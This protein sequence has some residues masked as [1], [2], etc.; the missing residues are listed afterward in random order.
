MPVPQITN[1]TTNAS[2]LKIQSRLQKKILSKKTETTE[3]TDKKE[4]ISAPPK[5]ELPSNTIIVDDRSISILKIGVDSELIFDCYGKL[6]YIIINSNCYRNKVN[7]T[8]TLS[9]PIPDDLKLFKK[10]DIKNISTTE[11]GTIIAIPTSKLYSDKYP[12]TETETDTVS[13]ILFERIGI[14][15]NFDIRVIERLKFNNINIKINQVLDIIFVNMNNF[16]I[17]IKQDTNFHLVYYFNSNEGIDSSSVSCSG[18]FSAD[19][20][21]KQA[22]EY[23]YNHMIINSFDNIINDYNYIC[24]M[25]SIYDITPSVIYIL[26]HDK[27]Y[28][29]LI[30]E[31]TIGMYEHCG[32][33]KPLIELNSI[34][35]ILYDIGTYLSYCANYNISTFSILLELP[36]KDKCFYTGIMDIT[37]PDVNMITKIKLSFSQNTTFPK[38][39]STIDAQYM[40]YTIMKKTE[41][42]IKEEEYNLRQEKLKKQ[43]KKLDLKES[44]LKEQEAINIAE[45][46]LKEEEAIKSKAKKQKEKKVKAETKKAILL[47]KEA[48]EKEKLEKEEILLKKEALEKEEIL[49]K[50]EA[51]EKEEILLK[52]EALEKEALEK[53]ALEKE[54]ILLKKEALEKEKLEKEAN[55]FKQE[56]LE[57][58]ILLKKERDEKDILLKQIELLEK[59]KLEKEHQILQLNSITLIKQ[60]LPNYSTNIIFQQFIYYMSVINPS[61]AH[62]LNYAQSDYHYNLLLFNNKNYVMNI[63]DILVMNHSHILYLKNIMI[64]DI[65]NKNN[66]SYQKLQKEGF[67]IFALYGSF[68]PMIYSLVLNNIGYIFNAF[69][70]TINPLN[71]LKDYDTLVLKLLDDYV[72]TETDYEFIREKS[73]IIG[74]QSGNIEDN[75]KSQFNDYQYNNDKPIT[76]TKIQ[77][78]SIHILLCKCWDLNYTSAI[79]LYEPD[80]LPYII[81]HPDFT[82]FIFGNTKT[83][84]LLSGKTNNNLY[85]YKITEKRLEKAIATWYN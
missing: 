69:G 28:K 73:F 44:I 27:N 39:I 34:N 9:V 30:L 6:K 74:Y 25:W 81:R 31:Y 66:Y 71:K 78:S 68:L 24:T 13:F 47:K 22:I 38:K 3:T 77:S 19:N 55:L 80:K 54:T 58:D 16:W 49:L 23:S 63:L 65:E 51:L 53:E 14:D 4:K 43:K 45:Q 59:E 61:L 41:T 56:A 8:H 83:I 1:N 33:F 29:V 35:T 21:N 20:S 76:R 10:K 52:K 46:L 36:N 85:D 12:K 2:K 40:I 17:I 15:D 48:L 11:I 26:V 67:N 42:T 32:I 64:P 70:N 84:Q 79:L 75:T 82:D 37:P 50:K 72:E 57:K 60:T 7:G 5:P 62:E 18:S